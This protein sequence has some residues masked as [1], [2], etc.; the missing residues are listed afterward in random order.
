MIVNY[1]QLYLQPYEE[2]SKVIKFISYNEFSVHP[3]YFFT[4]SMTSLTTLHSSFNLDELNLN[5]LDHLFWK[6]EMDREKVNQLNELL[7]RL[8]EINASIRSL[9]EENYS[10]PL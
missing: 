9:L 2:F 4:P 10:L 3:S 6:S 5:K 7:L 1:E 8:L